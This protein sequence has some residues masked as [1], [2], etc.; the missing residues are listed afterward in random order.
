MLAKIDP[1]RKTKD[2]KEA[3]FIHLRKLCNEIWPFDLDL[4]IQI[5][6]Q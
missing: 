2:G 4:A 5:T 3:D 1:Q 6:E